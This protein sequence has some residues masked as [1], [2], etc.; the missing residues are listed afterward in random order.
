MSWGRAVPIVL[1]G[2]KNRLGNILLWL[3]FWCQ[4]FFH[5]IFMVEKCVYFDIWNK[6]NFNFSKGPSYDFAHFSNLDL[7]ENLKNEP[8]HRGD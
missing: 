3:H 6:K 1:Q 7:A 5:I 2:V 4:E 8:N